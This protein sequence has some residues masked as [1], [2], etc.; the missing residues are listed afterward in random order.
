[1]LLV[2]GVFYSQFEASKSHEMSISPGVHY[3]TTPKHSDMP[4]EVINLLAEGVSLN[5]G[6]T[7]RILISQT[8]GDLPKQVGNKT[9]CALLGYVNA[10]GLSYDAIRNENPEEKL[11]KVY[12]FNSARKSMSTVLKLKDGSGF[13]VH[14]KGASEWVMRS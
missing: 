10:I 11:H 9:E 3:K 6:F 1:M 12:T 5:A 4:T 14:T 13:R 8:P 7:S 2:G